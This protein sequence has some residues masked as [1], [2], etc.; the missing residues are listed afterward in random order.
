MNLII[1]LIQI[2]FNNHIQEISTKFDVKENL[3]LLDIFPYL[4]VSLV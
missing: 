1:H 3:Y 2:Y 4:I